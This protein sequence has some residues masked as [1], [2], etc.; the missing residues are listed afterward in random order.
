MTA[1]LIQARKDAI[2]RGDKALGRE[3]YH[4]LIAQGYVPEQIDADTFGGSG[5]IAPAVEASAAPVAPE[6]TAVEA[7][8]QAVKPAPKRRGAKGD[9]G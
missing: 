8:E 7:P 2:A 5:D 9:E 3:I 1:D 4:Q 6:T